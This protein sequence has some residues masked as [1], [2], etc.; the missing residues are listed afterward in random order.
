MPLI[1]YAFDWDS[2]D[3]VGAISPAEA[4]KFPLLVRL[5][6][7][8]DVSF[9]LAQLLVGVRLYRDGLPV[10][11]CQRIIRGLRGVDGTPDVPPGGAVVT[12]VGLPCG[13]DSAGEYEVRTYLDINE[14]GPAAAAFDE[15][16]ETDRFILRIAD[17]LPA[18]RAD[19][20]TAPAFEGEQRL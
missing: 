17:D 6:N 12:T 16:T 10:E 19:P 7:K 4:D 8:G 20:A 18:F 1:D 9:E 3:R 5:E 11:S 14:V 13:L 2:P 15:A